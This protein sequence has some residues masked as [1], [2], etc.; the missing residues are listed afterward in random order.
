MKKKRFLVLLV[1]QCYLFKNVYKY[2][3]FIYF[4]FFF[5]S[6]CSFVV[7]FTVIPSIFN[8]A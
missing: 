1:L 4:I 2:F 7:L 5:T 3:L 8:S 6:V